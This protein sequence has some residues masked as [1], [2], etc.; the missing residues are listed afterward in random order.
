MS[1]YERL[2]DLI[3]FV[4]DCLAKVEKAPGFPDISNVRKK[5]DMAKMA[6]NEFGVSSAEY[7][8]QMQRQARKELDTLAQLWAWKS[9]V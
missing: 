3:S 7:V 6:L 1:D 8:I 5:I 2:Q 9:S 4:E